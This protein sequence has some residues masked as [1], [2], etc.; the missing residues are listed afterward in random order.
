MKSDELKL[1][2]VTGTSSGI[3][4]AAANELL[5]R[6]WEVIGV[7]RRDSDINDSNYMHLNIDLTDIDNMLNKI[8][9][10]VVKRL[11]SKKYE[12]IALV[13]NAAGT[14]E[15]LR[16]EQLDPKKLSDLYKLNVILPVWL[17]GFF[18]K[19]KAKESRLRIIK[20]SSGAA[21]KEYPGLATVDQKQRY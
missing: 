3:G 1:A 21:H 9:A 2:F 18:Y 7:A 6:G 14:G 19:N 5:K 4:Q 17:M 8:P 12:R 10:T 11:S 16:M 20:I 15:L 13:N